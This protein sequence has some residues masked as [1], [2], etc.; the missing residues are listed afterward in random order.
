ML[1]YSSPATLLPPPLLL[2]PSCPHLAPHPP[3]QE[4]VSG[5]DSEVY[6]LRH[7]PSHLVG[8]PFGLVAQH[9]YDTRRLILMG[10][11]DRQGRR[12]NPQLQEYRLVPLDMV[13]GWQG[14]VM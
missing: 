10:L 5:L 9:L 11:G 4:Y 7:F 14:D 6:E 13:G 3:P 1:A 2:T 12:S 8:L